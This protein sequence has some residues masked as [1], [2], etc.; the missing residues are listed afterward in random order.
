MYA[1]TQAQGRLDLCK[2]V[3]CI[4]DFLI[5]SI[6]FKATLSERNLGVVGDDRSGYLPLLVRL[7][8]C[9]FTAD[10]PVDSD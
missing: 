3:L 10:S 6:H 2:S 7:R 8:P 4:L 9:S 5:F 1:T